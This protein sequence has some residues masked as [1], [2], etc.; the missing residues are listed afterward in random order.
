MALLDWLRGQGRRQEQESDV[1]RAE[2]R[3]TEQDPEGFPERTE[4]PEQ[5]AEQRRQEEA[6]RHGGI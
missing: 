3:R 4:S 5:S 1:E 6:A 2:V